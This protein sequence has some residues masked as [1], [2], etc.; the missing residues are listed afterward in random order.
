M[1][2]TDQPVKFNFSRLPKPTKEAL[3]I[4]SKQDWIKK[5]WY[6]A[7]GTALALQF[8]HRVSIDL[9]FFSTQ[10][11]FDPDFIIRT[12]TPYGWETTIRE[13]GT[14]YGELKGAKISFLAYPYF[15]PKK[16]FIHYE[17]IQVLDG[18]DIA[19]MKIIAISQRGRKRDFFDLYWYVNNKESLLGVLERVDT[20]FPNLAHNYHHIF[21]SLNYFDEAEEDPDPHIF[22]DKSWED[23]K[24]YFL[25]IVPKIADQLL[26]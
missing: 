15:I 10:T 9:D 5:D 26:K 16:P 8:D 24:K 19:V 12:L 23:V 13:K 6:L 3:D 11:D 14:L 4:L 17:N 7:G 18:F 25:K 20:Q 21:K 1:D 2:Q 22:F